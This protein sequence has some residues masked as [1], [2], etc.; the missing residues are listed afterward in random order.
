MPMTGR[1]TSAGDHPDDHAVVVVGVATAV[2]G[3][4]ELR[5]RGLVAE[6]AVQDRAQPG[7]ARLGREYPR[8]HLPGG[9]VA[10]VLG[11]AAFQIGDPVCLVILMEADDSSIHRWPK[12]LIVGRALSREHGWR[13]L[14]E[15]ITPR[16]PFPADR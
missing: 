2:R 15:K 11:V 7:L 10:D 12:S 3:T 1:S 9:I 8:P 13:A 5:G 4:E 16:S 6:T 14:A